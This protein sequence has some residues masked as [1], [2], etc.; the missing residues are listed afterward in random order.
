VKRGKICGGSQKPGG[1][2]N[3]LICESTAHSGV[4]NPREKEKVMGETEASQR[5]KE[6]EGKKERPFGSPE[7][8]SGI[9]PWPR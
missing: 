4:Q 8:D 5:L 2:E 7:S 9:R 6:E 1:I 3:S